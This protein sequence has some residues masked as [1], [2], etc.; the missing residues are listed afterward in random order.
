MLLCRGEM[1]KICTYLERMAAR[2]QRAAHH[3]HYRAVEKETRAS[4]SPPC[5]TRCVCRA[6]ESHGRLSLVLPLLQT[7]CQSDPPR[8]TFA[9]VLQT[10]AR[11]IKR[12]SRRAERQRRKRAENERHTRQFFNRISCIGSITDTGRYSSVMAISLGCS[13]WHHLPTLPT[14]I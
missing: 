8:L 4:P 1:Q 6:D 11:R 9:D 12:R 10:R 3:R 7:N 2:R 5:R 13:F 14:Q